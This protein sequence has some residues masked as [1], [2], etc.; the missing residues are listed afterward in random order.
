MP[1]GLDIFPVAGRK[2][3]K[4]GEQVVFGQPCKDSWPFAR[5]VS[6]VIWEVSQ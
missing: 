4:V 6:V 2:D 3:G 5:P 1:T